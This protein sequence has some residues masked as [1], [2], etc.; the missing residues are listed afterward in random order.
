MDHLSGSCLKKNAKEIPETRNHA[1]TEKRISMRMSYNKKAPIRNARQTPLVL[2]FLVILF[3]PRFVLAAIAEGQMRADII[4]HILSLTQW[5]Q[6]LTESP[7]CPILTPTIL[8]V[9]QDTD[10]IARILTE[11]IKHSTDSNKTILSVS[12]LPSP[13][14]SLAIEKKLTDCRILYFTRN[15]MKYLPQF[16]PLI[17]QRP[18]LTIGETEIFCKNGTGMIGLIKNNQNI[19]IHINH[20]LTSAADFFFSADLLRHAILVTR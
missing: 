14:S 3:L 5:P 20:R 2:M 6:K 15:G 13:D 12:S 10:D 7:G 11:K 8:I 1:T 16:T 4:F 17:S 18:I 19:A 9:G